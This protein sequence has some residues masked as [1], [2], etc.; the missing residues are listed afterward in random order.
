MKEQLQVL[1]YKVADLLKSG[2][3]TIAIAESSAGGLISSHLLSV[4]GASAYYIG[5]AV[6][7]TRSAQKGFL[8][9]SDEEM[10]GLRSST[11]SYC[12]LNARKV[13]D[14]LRT[15]WGISETG[16]AG[17]TGN[18]Y[19]DSAGHSCVGVSGPKEKVIT[20]ETGESNRS[21]NM[22]IFTEASLNLLID[23]IELS[24]VP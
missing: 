12:L 23:C 21:E 3:Q 5:G 2:N 7:Y 19:G 15:T 4:P 8:G 22:E 13:K 1:S 16:A 6:V 20:L 10:E 14:V 11:E 24:L 17:P 18:R 9:V